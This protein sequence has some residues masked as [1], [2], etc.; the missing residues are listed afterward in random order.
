MTGLA[1]GI[2]RR[3]RQRASAAAALLWHAMARPIGEIGPSDAI[4]AG[5]AG[6]A[7]L[8]DLRASP[9]GSGRWHAVSEGTCEA[10]HARVTG[11][12]C[13]QEPCLHT[14]SGT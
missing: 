14:R 12:W 11:S 4:G 13:V 3:P 8:V 2:L 5:G 1:A 6:S 7:R 10:E 9:H